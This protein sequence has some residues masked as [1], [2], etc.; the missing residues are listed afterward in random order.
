MSSA[1][2][3]P[4]AIRKADKVKAAADAICDAARDKADNI[5]YT[6][7][8]VHTKAKAV[9]NAAKAKADAIRVAAYVKADATYKPAYVA[10]LAAGKACEAAYAK[11][12]DE[13]ALAAAKAVS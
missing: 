6:A 8:T 5:Y 1:K 2:T 12:D 9:V 10:Y 11:A 4:A 13:Y 3:T 7:I